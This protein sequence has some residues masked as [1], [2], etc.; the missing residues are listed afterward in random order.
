MIEPPP[1]ASTAGSTAFAQR[2]AL[3]R[4]TLRARSHSSS[5]ISWT[6]RAGVTIPALF[7]KMSIGYEPTSSF[8][9]STLLRLATSQSIAR[10]AP[11][12]A[13]TS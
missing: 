1:A 4:L 13:I 10:E 6:Q 11:P 7:T 5:A 9:C 12:L 2:K 3:F 8:I